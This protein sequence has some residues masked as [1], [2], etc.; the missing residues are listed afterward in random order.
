M[1][2]T[3]DDLA[4]ALRRNA[5]GLAESLGEANPVEAIVLLRL[6]RQ[7]RALEDEVRELHDAI[8]AIRMASAPPRADSAK[9]PY[10]GRARKQTSR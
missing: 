2:H 8:G 3:L 5:A 6:I 4:E 7:A 9:R 10:P 1:E